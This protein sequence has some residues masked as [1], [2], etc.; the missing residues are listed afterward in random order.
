MI[1]IVM[2]ARND[3]YGGNFLGR[4]QVSLNVLGELCNRHR[5]DAEVIIVEWNPPPNKKRLSKVLALPKI[6]LRIVTVSSEVHKAVDG[7]DQM[8]MFEYLAKNVGIRRANGE[9][10]LCTNPDIILSDEMIARLGSENWNASCFY[11]ASRSD[12]TAG[13]ISVNTSVDEQLAACR[14]KVITT[15]NPNDAAGDFL[16]MSRTNWLGLRGYPELL[17]N[18]TIDTCMVVLADKAG[19]TQ[20]DFGEPIF[21]QFHDSSTQTANRPQVAYTDELAAKN[22][23]EWGL[24][25]T[26]LETWDAGINA[27]KSAGPAPVLESIPEKV[28]EPKPPIADMRPRCPMCSSTV[29][30]IGGGIRRCNQCGHQWV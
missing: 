4:M 29:I 28:I 25:D 15:H 8:P 5:L 26:E 23:G 2:T 6:P 12:L 7:S 13:D 19:M 3:G 27:T 11:R 30:G 18:S 16:L 17:S 20:V 24:G 10:I 1:S 14:K 22:S 9:M 21:H